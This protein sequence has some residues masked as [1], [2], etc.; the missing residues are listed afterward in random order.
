[1]VLDFEA[2]EGMG[3]S[4]LDELLSVL[5]STV[6][7]EAK[8]EVTSSAV[9]NM[10]LTGD[11]LDA[12]VAVDHSRGIEVGFFDSDQAIK[13]FNHNTG[14]TVPT[15]KSIPS[16]KENFRPAIRDEIR[17]IISEHIERANSEDS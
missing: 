17:E 1:M 8:R 3:P 13:A 2:V 14:D 4:F 11:M 16:P 10:E 7:G 9:A 15:R 12:L 5:E 6:L